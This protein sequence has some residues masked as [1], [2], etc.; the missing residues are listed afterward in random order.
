VG[1]ESVIAGLQKASGIH[2]AT[3]TTDRAPREN[4]QDG[5]DYHFVTTEEFL[6]R[7]REGLFAEHARVYSGWKGL[8]RAEIEGPIERGQDVIIRTDVQGA[9]TWRKR[10]EGAVSIV[11]I[12]A[13]AHRPS[14]EHREQTKRRITGREPDIDPLDLATRLQELDE[15][16]ADV[17]NNDYV[18]VNHHNGL[19]S[20]I[21]EILAIIEYERANAERPEPRLIEA[22]PE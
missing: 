13:P 19:D 11:I 20:A 17:P 16:L 1:K 6:R 21:G 2:R 14:A 7:I 15:E 18:V 3:S 12:P 10:L 5:V 9:R 8:E 4:E 22:L